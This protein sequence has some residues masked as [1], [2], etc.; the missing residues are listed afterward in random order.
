MRRGDWLRALAAH[1]FDA[2]TMEHVVDP[3]IADLQAERASVA[4][5]WAVFKVIALC[6][7]EVSMRVRVAAVVSLLTAVSAAER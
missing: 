1:L 4:R 5:Y 6:L 3:A 7:P 2:H